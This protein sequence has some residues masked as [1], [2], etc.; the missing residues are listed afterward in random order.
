MVMKIF[1][2]FFPAIIKSVLSVIVFIA[3][4]GWAAYGMVYVIVNA[5]GVDIRREVKE[6]RENDIKHIDKRFDRIEKLILDY[7]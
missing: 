7:R 2:S 5:E 4:I 3:S 6:I 1:A